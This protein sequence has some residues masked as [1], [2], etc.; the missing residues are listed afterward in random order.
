MSLYIDKRRVSARLQ[1][2]TTK[3]VVTTGA[4]KPTMR[5]TQKGAHKNNKN[6]KN[7]NND[8]NA[9]AV[10]TEKKKEILL[11]CDSIG[12]EMSRSS[13]LKMRDDF[14]EHGLNGG[15]NTP[16]RHSKIKFADEISPIP[17]DNQKPLSRLSTLSTASIRSLKSASSRGTAVDSDLSFDFAETQQDDGDFLFETYGK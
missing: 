14:L 3:S 12:V 17:E 11:G 1:G 2:R 13:I 10:D 5:P 6:N 15:S 4:S 16:V 7:N 9:K 8:D